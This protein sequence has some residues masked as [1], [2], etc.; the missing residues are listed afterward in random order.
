MEISKILLLSQVVT[1]YA[2]HLI[3][4][5]NLL[6]IPQGVIHADAKY[7]F[8][9]F[10]FFEGSPVKLYSSRHPNHLDVQIPEE[11]FTGLLMDTTANIPIRECLGK[12]NIVFK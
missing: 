12:L 5:A 1:P 7:L 2:P 10:Y 6:G 11:S 3:D 8:I 9:D 4:L